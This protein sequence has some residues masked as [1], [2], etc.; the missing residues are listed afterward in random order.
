MRDAAARGNAGMKRRAL[1]KGLALAPLLVPAL[2]RA[3]AR[4]GFSGASSALP[5]AR[6]DE[7][8]AAR[9]GA[10]PAPAAVRRVFAA[11]PPAA[12]LVYALAPQTLL[13]WPLA[14]GEAA[15]RMLP[16]VPID[17]PQL[18]RL[19][20][21]GSTVS[22]ETLLALRPDLI[23][24]AGDVD[25]TYLSQAEQAWRQTHLPYVLAQGRLH[26][27][28]AQLREVGRLLGVPER[29]ARLAAAAADMLAL[30][31]TVL[32]AVPPSQ[33]PRVYY[34]RGPGGLETGLD[35]SINVEVIAA[36]GARN[37]AAQAGH[38]GLTRVS[39]E[40]ILA[41]DPQVIITQD[42][43]FARHAL[44]DPLWRGVAA[45]RG[46][47]VHCAPSLPF[48]WLDG[49]PGVNRL[50]GLRW[51]LTRLYPGLH[52]ELTPARLRAA[53]LAFH[54]LFYGGE[55]DAAA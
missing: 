2:A 13:G 49:P 55:A 52:P 40:Q 32:A 5:S 51:L 50:I 45:V 44:Q 38:G 1:L 48:G 36:A 33:R 46:R 8:L 37:V 41:W 35:G 26:E 16:A 34:G 14:L 18:G 29:G 3:G 31:R 19:A 7:I 4:D 11:G 53:T 39:M 20:G 42:P 47:R 28:P 43:G 10:V 24:D 6:D 12:V 17:L 27:H 22:A 15:R 9:Y 54:R 21:R 30:A 23:L 25:P